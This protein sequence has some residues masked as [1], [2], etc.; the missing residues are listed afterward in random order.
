MTQMVITPPFSSLAHG[1]RIQKTTIWTCDTI[2]AEC[3][4]NWDDL[5]WEENLFDGVLTC[6]AYISFPTCMKS[7]T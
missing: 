4:F 3:Y 5:V 6:T 2:F 7:F 1:V